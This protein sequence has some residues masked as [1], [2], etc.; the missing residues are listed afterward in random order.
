MTSRTYAAHP[1]Y[2]TRS[3]S[4][5]SMATPPES[6]PSYL[7]ADA[8]ARIAATS[9]TDTVVRECFKGEEASQWKKA[10]IR[11]FASPKPLNRSSQ[12]LAHVIASWTALDIQNFVSIG[13]GV[14]VP[15]IRH[16][17]MLLG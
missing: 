2:S 11:P 7:S 14:A 1:A 10:K 17:A 9:H 12:K 6:E 3:R 8:Q 16:L 15:Q 5:V 13:S 4:F